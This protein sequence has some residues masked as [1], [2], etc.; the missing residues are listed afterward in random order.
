MS[1]NAIECREC[2]HIV[3]RKHHNGVI[4][5]EAGIRTLWLVDGRTVAVCPCGRRVPVVQ[6]ETR[7]A[8]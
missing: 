7:K 5:T 1:S 2:G 4:R 8:A 6:R 3:A